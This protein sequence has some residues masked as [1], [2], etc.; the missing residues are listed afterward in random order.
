VA[1]R[2]LENACRLGDPLQR[3]LVGTLVVD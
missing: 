2:T 3:R 1:K